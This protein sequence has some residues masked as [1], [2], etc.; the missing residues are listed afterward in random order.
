MNDAARH[1]ELIELFNGR[2][3]L[4]QHTKGY[5]FSIDAVLLASFSAQRAQGAV[6]DL[7]TGSGIIP[8]LLARHPACSRITGIEIQPDLAALARKN[9]EL[10]SCTCTADIICADIKNLMNLLPAEGFDAAVANPP[11]YRVGTGR[12]NPDTQNAGARHEIH[13]TIDDF[14]SAASRLL[15]RGGRFLTV[16][17]AARVVDLISALRAK[18]IEPKKLRAVQPGAGEPATMVLVEAVKGAGIEMSIE[19]PMILYAR[20]GEYTPEVQNIFKGL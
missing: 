12:V 15:R 17:G 5:R 3:R 13:A 20:Q 11:F 19:P 4:Y 14:V 10:N 2:L 1:A 6:V 9:I 8:V 16:Y 18:S 7:G